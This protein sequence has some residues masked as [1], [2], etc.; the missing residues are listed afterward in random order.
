[1]RVAVVG[2]VMAAFLPARAHAIDYYLL[3]GGDD[4]RGGLIVCSDAATPNQAP[5]T[6]FLPGSSVDVLIH[7]DL[8]GLFYFRTSV[9]KDI[10]RRTASGAVSPAHPALL[11]LFQACRTHDPAFAAQ[12]RRNLK[13]FQAA[14]GDGP[15]P[16]RDGGWAAIVQ[17]LK[18]ADHI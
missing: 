2:L 5:R 8:D 4:D 15:Q 10:S 6:A 1:M 11:D 14:T 18:A 9:A 12:A 3:A 13:P 17:R 16:D 7:R